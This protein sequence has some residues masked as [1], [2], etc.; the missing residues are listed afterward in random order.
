MRDNGI[1]IPRDERRDVFEEFARG[2]AATRR[3]TPGVGL[4]L[5]FVRAIVRAHQRNDRRRPP[6]QATGSTFRLRLPRG[7][8]DASAGQAA[9]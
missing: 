4:G 5:A 9:A 7:R 6:G 3:G 1:G 2:Q 8:L